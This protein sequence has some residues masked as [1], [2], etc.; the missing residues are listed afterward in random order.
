VNQ[1]PDATS[2]FDLMNFV[3]K[4]REEG[5]AIHPWTAER[6]AERGSLEKDGIVFPES[7]WLDY[8]LCFVTSHEKQ[9]LKVPAEKDMG[10]C[11][12]NA[13]HAV[14]ELETA[15]ESTDPSTFQRF[16]QSNCTGPL[17]KRTLKVE[18]LLLSSD[19]KKTETPDWHGK[20]DDKPKKKEIS[21]NEKATPSLSP[22]RKPSQKFSGLHQVFPTRP[23]AISTKLATTPGSRIKAK[24]CIRCGDKT[25]LRSSCKVPARSWEK[26]FDLGPSFW[27]HTLKKKGFAQWTPRPSSTLF[28]TVP[29]VAK[30]PVFGSAKWTVNVGIG[31]M[32]DIGTAR[33]TVLDNL[34]P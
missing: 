29:R 1:L 7:T 26:E 31:T 32:S 30:S 13:G 19:S 10:A 21:A 6:R 11:N 3:L 24:S 25:H 2:S 15:V 22:S 14:S 18:K 9:I 12:A 28:V 27:E 34:R 4:S 33:S 17:A 16:R 23:T 20:E 8:V 5:L